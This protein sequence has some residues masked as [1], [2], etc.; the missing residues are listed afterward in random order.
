MRTKNTIELTKELERLKKKCCCAESSCCYEEVTYAEAAA[1]IASESLV[2]NTM[3]KISDRGDLGIFLEAISTT[4]FNQEGSR[5]MLIPGFN[6]VPLWNIWNQSGVY[7]EGEYC[8]RRGL[9]YINISGSNVTEP[10]PLGTADW[11]LI[12]KSSFA[13]DEYEPRWFGVIYNFAEDWISKQWDLAGNIV[14]VPS[15]VDSYDSPHNPCDETQWEFATYN[16]NSQ[17]KMHNNNCA[18][19]II[20]NVPSFGGDG[21]FTII[22]NITSGEIIDNYVIQSNSHGIAYNF[23]YK[24]ANNGNASESRATSINGNILGESLSITNND[25]LV[26]NGNTCLGIDS[27]SN[28]VNIEN[29][30]NGGGIANNTNAGDIS[31]NYNNGNIDANSNDG[32]ILNN[33]NN[34]YISANVNLGEISFNSNNGN[35][36]SCTSDP[37]PCNIVN[38]INNGNISG[39]FVADVTDTIVNKP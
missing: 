3:Y 25:V 5:L 19:G 14:G 1:L 13:N 12:P 4:E 35:I 34:G 26:I 16:S 11:E 18:G 24:I 22:Y 23:C 8:K 28:I 6:T 27:N 17:V 36:E 37:N 2:P 7:A 32:G 30:H 39:A 29:N 33:I 15:S 21:Q 31:N 38:N 10:V 20:D 9:V